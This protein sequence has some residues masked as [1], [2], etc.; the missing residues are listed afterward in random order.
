LGWKLA[1]LALSKNSYP[2]LRKYIDDAEE[3]MSDEMKDFAVGLLMSTGAK[4]NRSYGI[5]SVPLRSSQLPKATT[6]PA[7]LSK[8]G[9]VE[10]T[11]TVS[12]AVPLLLNQDESNNVDLDLGASAGVTPSAV[13]PPPLLPAA[14][15]KATYEQKGLNIKKRVKSTVVK[16]TAPTATTMSTPINTQQSTV[17]ISK[18]A[19]KPE[20]KGFKIP[21][22]RRRLPSEAES[23]DSSDG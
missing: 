17:A 3:S 8:S 11:V 16:T 19:Y 9:S 13:V 4:L 2:I 18:K 1:P 6:Q 23:S 15:R 10:S 21:L 14:Q 12:D 7:L 22:K 5:V 20:F